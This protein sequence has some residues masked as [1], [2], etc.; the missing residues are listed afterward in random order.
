MAILK[1]L[2]SLKL[3][4][5]KLVEENKMKTKVFKNLEEL[6][7][8][9]NEETNTYIF[10]EGDNWLNVDI[11]FTLKITANIK[12]RDINACDINAWDINAW[13]INAC[14]INACDIN[15]CDINACDI[16]ACDINAW[17]INACDI[18]ACD[19]N[20]RDINA[21]DIVF[22]AICMATQNLVCKSITG[23]RNN[24][25][26]LCLD[27]EPVIKQSEENEND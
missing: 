2:Y 27:S 12:A 1:N 3:N 17:D 8:Y 14:D 9:Y 19:I 6:K 7:K 16:N 15:A 26:Y 5:Q 13:D 20:A 23:E 11:Q 18:N 4:S 24:A 25:K 21:W 10:K 22:F